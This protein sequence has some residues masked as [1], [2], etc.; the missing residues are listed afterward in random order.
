[1]ARRHTH[2]T[3]ALDHQTNRNGIAGPPASKAI[4]AEA[5]F[6]LSEPRNRFER[7]SRKKRIKAFLK[8]AGVRP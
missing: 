1:M 5:I 2:F 6:L 7:R 3:N 4:H 8:V